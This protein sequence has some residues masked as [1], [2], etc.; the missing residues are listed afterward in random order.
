MTYCLLQ[1][2]KKDLK[3]LTLKISN[4]Q[5]QANQWDESNYNTEA[6]LDELQQYI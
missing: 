4:L 3:D 5:K 1:S 6:A 2:T